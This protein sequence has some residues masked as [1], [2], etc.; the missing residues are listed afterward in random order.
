ML[1]SSIPER[2]VAVPATLQAHLLREDPGSELVLLAEVDK[3]VDGQ[4]AEAYR[5]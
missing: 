4:H 2:Y 1:V 3:P 5:T